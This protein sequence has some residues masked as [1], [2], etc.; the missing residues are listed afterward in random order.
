M[1]RMFSLRLFLILLLL[2]PPIS[3]HGATASSTQT[4]QAYQITIKGVRPPSTGISPYFI[5]TVKP[6]WRANG[7]Y[8]GEYRLLYLAYSS[9][10]NITNWTLRYV[11]ITNLPG[12]THKL[13]NVTLPWPTNRF[14]VFAYHNDPV[15]HWWAEN[16]TTYD[17]FLNMG[18]PVVV[19]Y[20]PSNFQLIGRVE[21]EY[22]VF[23]GFNT[24]FKVPVE[25]LLKY[26]PRHFLNDLGGILYFDVVDIWNA[27]NASFITYHRKC[28]IIYPLRLS[29]WETNGRVYVGVNFSEG[30]ELKVNQSIPILLYLNNETLK[31][32]VDVLGLITPQGDPLRNLPNPIIATISQTWITPTP[33]HEIFSEFFDD[34]RYPRY[35]S[36][37]Y[38]VVSNG[39]SAVLVVTMKEPGWIPYHYSYLVVNGVPKFF[40]LSPTW[41]NTSKP[42]CW[43][44][45]YKFG[46]WKGHYELLWESSYNK[47]VYV[48]NGTCWRLVS[49]SPKG[50]HAS[51]GSV[52]RGVVEGSYMVFRFN[53]T[54]LRIPLR[55]LEEYYPPRVWEWQLIAAKDGNG[56]LILPAVWFY[57]GNYYY[58]GGSSFGVVWGPGDFLLPVDNS[59]GVYALYY[60]NGTLRPAFDLLR[61]MG[62]QGDWMR[63]LPGFRVL[64]NQY[65]NS[66][67]TFGVCSAGT[68]TQAER[69]NTSTRTVGRTTTPTSTG[70]KEKSIC[71]PGFMVLLAVVGL[72]AE[73][74][75]KRG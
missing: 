20:K 64:P 24:T 73:R 75:R 15:L 14:D 63:N 42:W 2:I 7:S 72:L 49:E 40:N 70:T 60:V 33:A 8:P 57:Y 59:S 4:F 29:Y 51:N 56:Y 53:G 68:Q 69:T 48:L 5:I 47:G 11:N 28:F 9:Y 13:G 27:T 39:S 52:A 23:R 34:D 38:S 62:P 18:V 71:G 10:Y 74:T 3:F 54:T 22:V 37:F 45:E 61:L 43:H 17:Y 19:K 41:R 66:S 32:I 35:V 46:V 12:V 44:C 1:S 31:P 26:Y 25:E 65:F 30:V 50:F 21:G 67:V 16:N 6:H 36:L 58:A 55:E